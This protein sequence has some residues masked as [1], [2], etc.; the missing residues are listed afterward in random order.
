V[1]QET[2]NDRVSFFIR[3]P[4]VGVYYISVYAQPVNGDVGSF[5][6]TKLRVELDWI[7]LWKLF[8]ELVRS[9]TLKKFLNFDFMR[10]W[11]V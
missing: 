10:I 8:L 3:L 5:L 4:R 6:N 11:M 9:A 1:I 7:C 2:T